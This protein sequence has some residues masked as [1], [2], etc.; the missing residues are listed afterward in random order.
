[1]LNFIKKHFFKLNRSLTRRLREALLPKAYQRLGTKYGG[2]WIDKNLLENK[3]PLLID[4]GLG[5]DIS[6]PMEFLEKHNGYVIGID[7]DPKSISFCEK[8]KPK[9]MDLYKKAFWKKSGVALKFHLARSVDKLPKGAD[10]SG[11]VLSSHNYVDGGM[12]IEVSTTSLSE[13]LT[14]YNR[15]T[16]DVLK[17]DIE[18]AE[19]DVISDLI[20]SGQIHSIDQ[21]LVEFHHGVTHFTIN[22]TSKIVEDLKL[23]N[24]KLIHI[25]SRNYIFR[26]T[27][28]IEG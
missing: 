6:F 20:S 1:M 4:C 11:S 8:I 3:N 16:C 2:W 19:Y 14:F 23:A 26:R 22:D 17:L 12:E 10:E 21:L 24:F 27:K 15:S 28:I 5:R 13:I 18:G 7:P 9:N 25:E